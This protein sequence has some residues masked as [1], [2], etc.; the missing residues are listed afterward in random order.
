MIE[1]AT[2]LIGLVTGPRLVEMAVQGPVTAIEV[3]LDGQ[4]VH[5]LEDEPWAIEVDFGDRL[6][7]HRLTATAL[8]SNGRTLDSTYQIVNY[9]R[10]SFE[11]AIILDPMEGG[12]T[13]SGR[14][15]WQ[16]VLNAPPRTVELQF[17][18]QSVAVDTTGSFRLPEYDPETA[19]ALEA[20]VTFADGSI[21]LANLTFGGQFIDQTT[22][23]LTAVPLTSEYS[24]P[25]K[26][27]QVKNWLQ[28][29]GVALEV[30]TATGPRG[31]VVV[32]RDDRLEKATTSTMPWRERAIR[33]RRYN[34]SAGSSHWVMAICAR[35]LEDLPGTFRLSNPTEIQPRYGLR[36]V[37]L[38]DGPLIPNKSIDGR[39]LV[40]KEQ[41][42]WDSLAVAGL[43]AARKNAPRLV[44]LM[45]SNRLEDHSQLSVDQ[46]VDYLRSIHVPMLVWAPAAKDLE[47]F[48]LAQYRRVYLG[49]AGLIELGEEV[50]RQLSSQ[51]IVWVQGEHL[52]NEISL[53]ATAPANATL[54]E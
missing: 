28:R 3:A 22:S 54:V 43:N 15:L 29:N 47:T 32:L 51:T 7:P 36:H 35:P 53:S 5:R 37:L 44:V 2:L 18:N 31:Y 19:H 10:S 6:M 12:P 34:G 14:V 39:K 8:D 1:F 24:Q 40:K 16:G 9:S 49:P 20:A 11:A 17:D 48:G 41:K 23:A 38:H 33:A 45:L 30:F 4:L 13:Q 21:G 46:A 42:L 26:G 52:P 27:H 25:W 50:E